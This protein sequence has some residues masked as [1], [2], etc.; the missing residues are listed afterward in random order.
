MGNIEQIIDTI[1][2]GSTSARHAEGDTRAFAAS[3]VDSWGRLAVLGLVSSIGLLLVAVSDTLSRSG[4]GRYDLLFWLGLITIVM[5]IAA[6]LAS[7]T[8][9]RRERISLVILLGF[10][11]YL[12][13]VMHSPYGFTFSDELAHSYNATQI[14]RTGTLFT[15]NPVLPVTPL[16]PGLETITAA[17][18]SL[19]GLSVFDAG[20]V[21]I[22]VARLILMLALFLF[23]EQLSGSARLAGIAALLYAANANFLFWSAQFS[24][25]SVA[26]PLAVLVIFATTR[27]AGADKAD[28]HVGLTLIALLCIAAV[29]ITH[30]VTAYLLAFF[31]GLWALIVRFRVHL[32]F[33]DASRTLIRWYAGETSA[34]QISHKIR[35]R[36]PSLARQWTGT[37]KPG[38]HAYSSSHP[39][40][41]EVALFALVTTLAWLIFVASPTINY[42]SPVIGGAVTSITQIITGEQSGRELFEAIRGYVA[43]WWERLIALGSIGLM[44][45]ATPLGL[46]RIWQQFR[47]HP[48][49]QLL[50]AAALAYFVILILR[51]SPAAWETGNRASEFLFIG[52]A[53]VVAFAVV[54]L[55]D[56]WSAFWQSRA[57]VLGSIA[58]LFVGGVIAGWTPY[59]RLSRPLQVTVGNVTI[60]SQS[61]TTALWMRAVLGP[62]NRVLTDE[63][64]GR[65]MLTYGDQSTLVGRNASAK[66][67]LGASEIPD[68]L[69]K[70]FRQRD[71]RYIAVD[72]RLIS[73]DNMAGYY[74]DE[75]NGGPVASTELFDPGI[76]EKFDA[77]QNVSR[78]YDSGNIVIYDMKV[79]TDE[80]PIN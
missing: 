4:M 70:V 51:F 3:R 46:R 43:P 66:D 12:V 22:G 68:W 37:A 67:I 19:S 6:R 74:F 5:P 33:I 34:Q 25:E 26:L 38:I 23:F 80:A 52:L 79:M 55:W 48:V 57:L 47:E 60:E 75:T 13:K 63:S 42:L 49:V 61:M 28:Q 17:L 10:A 8:P 78:I 20:L 39:G 56:S 73:W 18:A 62:H 35:Q 65:L 71:V 1:P 45:L 27:R 77:L 15:P 7:S 32:L 36:L 69:G 31:L 58:A 21:I 2:T 40:V 76:Y 44:L 54:D 53:F 30:H 16:Y 24:Y 14:V 50:M 41:G 59:V 9:A 29:V 11:L 72:R 64:N